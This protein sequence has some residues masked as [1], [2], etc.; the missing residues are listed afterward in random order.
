MA[1][2]IVSIVNATHNVLSVLDPDLP[3]DFAANSPLTQALQVQYHQAGIV[4]IGLQEGR[5][6]SFARPGTHYFML[7]SGAVAGQLGVELW[8]SLVIP[9]HTSPNTPVAEIPGMNTF[10]NR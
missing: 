9:Y 3:I 7:G 5:R 4:T 10:R 2:K 6:P 1:P 8:F